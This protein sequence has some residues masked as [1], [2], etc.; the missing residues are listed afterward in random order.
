MLF[1][2]PAHLRVCYLLKASQRKCTNVNYRLWRWRKNMTISWR[3]GG[4]QLFST[5]FLPLHYPRL[6][7]SQITYS[8]TS[9]DPSLEIQWIHCI[10]RC[11]AMFQNLKCKLQLWGV[12]SPT[13]RRDGQSIVRLWISRVFDK[14]TIND[15]ETIFQWYFQNFISIHCIWPPM[16]PE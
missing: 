14:M 3:W 2:I 15:G 7:W 10:R 11:E 16:N 13:N 9:W 12:Q 6:D 1:D 5:I 8:I 4:H